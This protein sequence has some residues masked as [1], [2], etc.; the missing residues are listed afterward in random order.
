MYIIPTDYAK[1]GE[2]A[3]SLTLNETDYEGVDIDDKSKST[4]QSYILCPMSHDSPLK[5]LLCP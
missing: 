2:V 3:F 4:D 5:G 1:F